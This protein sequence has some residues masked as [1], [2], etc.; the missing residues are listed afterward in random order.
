MVFLNDSFL[1]S[2]IFISNNE[3]YLPLRLLANT[4]GCEVYWDTQRIK[5]L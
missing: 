5:Q 2:D 4:L 1:T 3:V